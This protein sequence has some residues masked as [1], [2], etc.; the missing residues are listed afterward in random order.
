MTAPNQ[1]SVTRT[2][3]N[4]DGAPTLLFIHGFLDDAAVWDGVIAALDQE[5]NTVSYDLPGFGPRAA[6]IGDPDALSL[7]SLAAEAGEILNG[8]DTPVI[9]VGQSMG[10]QIAEIV[11]AE[12]P[13]Q[14]DGL[15]LLTPVPLGGTHLPAEELDPFRSL[16]NDLA[17]QRAARSAL[18][19]GLKALQL[20]RLVATGAGVAPEVVAR[21]ADLWNDGVKDTP[22]TSKYASPVLVIRGAKDGFVTE[23]LAGAVVGRFADVREHVIDRGGHWLHVEY[24][25]T[26]AATIL[27]FKDSVAS[28]K[29]AQGWRRS[30][31]GQSQSE[32]AEQFADEIVFEA[33]TLAKPVEGKQSVAAVLA[34]A[35]SIYESLEFTAEAQSTSTTYLQWRA[36]AF[37]GM[38]ID[39]VTVLERDASGKIVTAAIHH[40]PLGAVLRFSAEIRDRLAGVIPA[41]YFLTE[42][43]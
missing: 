31:A 13:D 11:A 32:F 37:G 18:S 33:T 41:D 16:A 35:S 5:L 7:E 12:H 26:V 39:G 15:V 28:G 2:S 20:D 6:T 21:Y 34:T 38:R 25:V 3:A 43:T 10:S 24:P 36:T 27:D 42:S 14:V 29:T 9:V 23:E 40:R 19:P 1:T 30:F 4:I 22:A 17:A 8:I